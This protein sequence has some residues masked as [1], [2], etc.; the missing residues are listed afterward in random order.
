[1]A[2]IGMTASSRSM[3]GI[4][5]YLSDLCVSARNSDLK[6][7]RFREKELAVARRKQNQKDDIAQGLRVR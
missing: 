5:A 4:L 2:A 1:M 6:K 7:R 3:R